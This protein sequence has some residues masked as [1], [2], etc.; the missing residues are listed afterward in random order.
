MCSHVARPRIVIECPSDV[1]SAFS[2]FSSSGCEFAEQVIRRSV[3]ILSTG[4]SRL[5]R[6]KQFRNR[7]FDRH[8][9]AANDTGIGQRPTDFV[10]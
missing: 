1:S 10:L 6:L 2:A 9:P 5:K 3:R 4:K 7:R 8:V